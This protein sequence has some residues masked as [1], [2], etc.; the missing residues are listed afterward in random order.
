MVVNAKF[1]GA[2][3]RY[4][5]IIRVEREPD[6]ESGDV[7]SSTRATVLHLR[8]ADDDGSAVFTRR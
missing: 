4:C 7:S 1:E 5:K 6:D 3:W 2:V 8:R